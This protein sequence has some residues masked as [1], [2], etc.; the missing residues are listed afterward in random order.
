MQSIVHL[1][2]F[3]R[4]VCTSLPIFSQSANKQFV[5]PFYDQK[6]LTMREMKTVHISKLKARAAFCEDLSLP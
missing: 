6:P 2:V 3:M 1:F 5:L 4:I